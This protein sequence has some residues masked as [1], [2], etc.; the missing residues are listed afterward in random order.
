[1]FA[2]TTK[3]KRAVIHEGFEIMVLSHGG[4]VKIGAVMAGFVWMMIL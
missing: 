3:G 4:D 1:M 2:E